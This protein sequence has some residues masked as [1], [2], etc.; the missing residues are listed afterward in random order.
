MSKKNNKPVGL[1]SEMMNWRTTN[2][3]H[4]I[5]SVA[6]GVDP[7]SSV[8]A[9]RVRADIVLAVLV[10]PVQTFRTLVDVEAGDAVRLQ[11]VAGLTAAVVR[12]NRV[13]TVLTA[14]IRTLSTLVD[15]YGLNTG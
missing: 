5:A 15:I 7:V 9:A 12:A 11:P 4:T 13:A 1:S 3:M 6:V 14:G 8:A 10:T 2:R